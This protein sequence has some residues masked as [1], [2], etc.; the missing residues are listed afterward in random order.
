[1]PGSVR[2]QETFLFLLF[3]ATPR[4]ILESTAF[5]CVMPADSGP[6]WVHSSVNVRLSAACETAFPTSSS[7]MPHVILTDGIPWSC[8]KKCSLFVLVAFCLYSR[9]SLGLSV[10]ICVF[11]T[12]MCRMYY[13]PKRKN[14]SLLRNGGTVFSPNSTVAVEALPSLRQQH[15][16]LDVDL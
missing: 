4:G 2:E 1:M 3:A 13:N 8:S 9:V 10:H 14:L 16:H 11:C 12:M 6:V 7:V 5:I 15:C